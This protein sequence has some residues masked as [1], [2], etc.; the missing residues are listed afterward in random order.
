M[1]LHAKVGIF[2]MSYA[3]VPSFLVSV[4]F[5]FILKFFNILVP[6]VD[7]RM[8]MLV[9]YMQ[10]KDAIAD[11]KTPERSDKYLLSWLKGREVV[12]CVL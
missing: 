12:H 3:V 11:L 7:Y 10:F 2:L 9:F 4:L 1:K 8:C 5:I 6:R